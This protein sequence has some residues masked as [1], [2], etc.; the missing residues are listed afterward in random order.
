MD[1]V[2]D[3]TGN[4]IILI[5]IIKLESVALCSTYFQSFH[6]GGPHDWKC[7][8]NNSFMISIEM[9]TGLLNQDT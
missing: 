7:Q 2:K 6:I 4:T 9:L 1:Y 8:S 5:L 3:L